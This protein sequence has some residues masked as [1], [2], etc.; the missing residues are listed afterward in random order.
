MQFF[1]KQKLSLW[2]FCILAISVIFTSCPPPPTVT[3]YFKVTFHR[4]ADTDETTT[5]EFQK[6]QPTAMLPTKFTWEGFAF[7]GWATAKDATVVEYK[8]GEVI[9]PTANMD[10]YAVWGKLWTVAFESNGGDGQMENQV[11]VD[12]VPT[13]IS[14]CSFTKDGY[15][16]AGWSLTLGGAIE[17]ENEATIV[18]AYDET[19]SDV[20]ITKLYAVWKKTVAVRYHANNGTTDV[21]EQIVMFDVPTEVLENSFSSNDE[22]LSFAGWT[23]WIGPEVGPSTP[24]TSEDLKVGNIDSETLAAGQVGGVVYWTPNYV[25]KLN[26]KEESEKANRLT[27]ITLNELEHSG[28][29]DLYAVWKGLV[30]V[31]KGSFSMGGLGNSQ[32]QPVHEVTFTRDILVSTHEVTQG[33]FFDITGM[34]QIGLGASSETIV[35]D[36]HP[37]YNV[38]WY[39]AVAYCNKRSYIEGK[40]PCYSIDGWGETEWRNLDF[41]KLPKRTSSGTWMVEAPNYWN[42]LKCNFDADGYRLPT[43]AEWEYAARVNLPSEIK[44]MIFS[45]FGVATEF[46][47]YQ[48]TSEGKDPAV[49]A[50]LQMISPLYAVCADPSGGTKPVMSKRSNANKLYD[51]AGNVAE[52]CWDVYGSYTVDSLSDPE[53]PEWTHDAKHMHKGGGYNSGIAGNALLATGR[54]NAWSGYN[55]N[56]LGFRVVRTIPTTTP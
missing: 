20:N 25:S 29:V 26:V 45:G 16:F 7:K 12:G 47:S 46:S 52:F 27:K 23:D 6:A 56:A 10:L 11:F 53:G 32:S 42:T 35:A 49:V 55:E 9:S 36:D 19:I 14:A 48:L 41:T 38:S 44:S 17:Y 28:G 50:F 2:V 43:E 5:Q 30:K 31:E 33:E 34:N 22:L 37:V 1:N 21:V 13:A 24:F 54:Q 40:T 15:G 18:V 4:N 51:M 8:D 39:Q 3:E